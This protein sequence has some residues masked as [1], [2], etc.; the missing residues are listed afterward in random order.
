MLFVWQGGLSLRH[1]LLLAVLAV[2]AAIAIV[3]CGG[4]GA[5]PPAGGQPTDSPQTSEPAPADDPGGRQGMTSDE[6]P[7]EPAEP[8]ETEP[9]EQSADETGEPGSLLVRYETVQVGDTYGNFIVTEVGPA[10]E[11]LPIGP[12]NFRV[13][14]SGS[15]TVTGEFN[16]YEDL[17]EGG[18]V[19]W[20]GNFDPESE[21]LLPDLF[22]MPHHPGLL[23]SNYEAVAGEFPAPESSGRATVVIDNYVLQFL[24]RSDLYPVYADIAVTLSVN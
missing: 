6:R 23:V 13:E 19:L 4:V 8:S 16:H 22:E 7:A 3:A 12:D 1:R 24:D 2:V 20:L 10:S 18:T 9:A 14:F 11:V 21:A 17:L 15:A 5:Q